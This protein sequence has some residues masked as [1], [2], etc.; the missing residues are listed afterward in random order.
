MKQNYWDVSDI[1]ASSEKI[2][3]RFNFTVPGIGHLDNQPGK[4]IKKDTKVELPFWLAQSLAVAPVSGDAS[5]IMLLAPDA[6]NNTV[7]NAIK[8]DPVSIDLH[9]IA[10]NFYILA[11]RWCALFTDEE[12][13][14]TLKKLC[15]ERAYEINNFA[16]NTSK[17]INNNFILSLDEF[18]KKLYKRTMES[19]R[20]LRDWLNDQA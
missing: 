2:P 9:S 20:N 12:L 18:E 14:E 5:I 3:T 11:E 15:K 19:N 10:P 17:Q 16:S 13:S 8:S 6:L 1:L 7:Q 4:A